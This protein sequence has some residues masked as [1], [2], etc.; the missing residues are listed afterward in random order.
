M[1][2]YLLDA[3]FQPVAIID[4]FSS[5]LWYRRYTEPGE[6]S[7]VCGLSRAA[8]LLAAA[9]VYRNDRPETGIIEAFERKG[10][11]VTVSGRF[12]E[13][14]LDDEIIYPQ[15]D[16]SGVTHERIAA[17]LVSSLLPHIPCSP[18]VGK[19]LGEEVSISL[20]GNNLMEYEY[21]LLNSQEL[22]PRITYDY[23]AGTLLFSVWQGLDR[24]QSQTVNS[25]A[26]FSANWENLL[27]ASYSI[28]RKSMRNYAIVAGG[29]AE[30]GSRVFRIIDRRSGSHARKLFVS[31]SDRQ[32]DRSEDEFNAI[33]DEKGIEKLARYATVEKFDVTIDTEANLRYM[34]DYDLGDYCTVTDTELGISLDARLTEI[35]ED[36]EEGGMSLVARFGEGYLTVPEYIRRRYG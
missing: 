22:S 35:E 20:L 23:A 3:D 33:L 27:S 4:D 11:K 7:L 30:D 28:S 8:E 26:V 16:F 1:D 36:W 29:E 5:L 17:A 10:S 18:V 25:W 32:D 2:I 14:L 31:L 24:R 15:Q 34:V 21:E 9:Y 6:F 19:G 13:A 12:L